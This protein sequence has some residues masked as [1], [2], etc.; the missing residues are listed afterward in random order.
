MQEHVVVQA[1]HYLDRPGHGGGDRPG[2]HH[3]LG[4]FGIRLFDIHEHLQIVGGRLNAHSSCEL[5]ED[6]S[7]P[8]SQPGMHAAREP[9][10]AAAQG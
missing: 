8:G 6:L 10:V 1:G 9:W 3:A 7:S 2:V 4:S 5:K